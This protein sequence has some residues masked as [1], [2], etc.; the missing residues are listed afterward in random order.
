MTESAVTKIVLSCPIW[1]R[2]AVGCAPLHVP[3]KSGDVAGEVMQSS[4]LSQYGSIFSVVY[5]QDVSND[6][7]PQFCGAFSV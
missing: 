2:S 6:V 5:S 3:C 4:D 7:P 1:L